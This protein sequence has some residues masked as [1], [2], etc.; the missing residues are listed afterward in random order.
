MLHIWF[1]VPYLR[2]ASHQ[3][4]I[5]MSQWTVVQALSTGRM[6]FMINATDCL[7][8]HQLVQWQGPWTS[9]F[10]N[11]P[12]RLCIVNLLCVHPACVW[13]QPKNMEKQL[14]ALWWTQCDW[15]AWPYQSDEQSVWRMFQKGG[16]W[17]AHVWHFSWT[18]RN[19]PYNR[20]RT[21]RRSDRP[22]PPAW[23]ICS[24]LQ[25]GFLVCMT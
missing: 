7:T 22:L 24:L 23:P 19:C 3:P 2:M 18:G 6:I 9:D 4:G 20:P 11:G 8:V 1:H 17:V 5:A 10:I 14:L 12:F 13:S 15:F 16:I 25:A 21:S